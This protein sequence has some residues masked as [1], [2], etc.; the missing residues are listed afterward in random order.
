M[1]KDQEAEAAVE[2][3][4]EE[5]PQEMV[6]Q[7]MAQET[8]LQEKVVTDQTPPEEEEAA[9]VAV[10]VQEPRTPRD[11][12]VVAEALRSTMTTSQNSK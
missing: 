10:V 11:L 6:L 4:E 2:T 3:E 1:V 8:V 9:E 7:E 12:P 5:V